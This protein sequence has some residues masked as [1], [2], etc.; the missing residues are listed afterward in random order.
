MSTDVEQVLAPPSSRLRR[1]LASAIATSYGFLLFI[2]WFNPLLILSTHTPDGSQRTLW[3]ALAALGVVFLPWL[4]LIPRRYFKLQPFERDGRLYR[5]L[6]VKRFRYVVSEGEGIQRLARRIDPNWR[7]PLTKLS[8]E[9]RIKWTQIPE[10]V[11]LGLI[12]LSLP[13]IALLYYRGFTTLA[14]LYLL[15]N[16]P[17]NIYPILLL[18]YTRAKLLRIRAL[19]ANQGEKE[20]KMTPV[21]F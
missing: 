21:P 20:Q 4:F 9:D 2:A 7:A 16:I 12:F 19:Q 11:H 13:L 14:S 6:G 3:T 8:Y 10:W 5:R 18:R 15:S 17:I 1:F